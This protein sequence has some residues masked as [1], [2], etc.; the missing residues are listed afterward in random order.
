MF[1]APS[2]KSSTRGRWRTRWSILFAVKIFEGIEVLLDTVFI[3]VDL[4]GTNIVN[5]SALFVVKYHIEVHF[6]GV[7]ADRGRIRRI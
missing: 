6:L 4:V 1:A 3:D 7:D 2:I 5:S